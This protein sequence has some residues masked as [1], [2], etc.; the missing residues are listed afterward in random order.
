MPR[1]RVHHEGHLSDQA[2]YSEVGRG[3]LKV[4]YGYESTP[5]DPLVDL[6]DSTSSHK[7]KKPQ[8]EADILS[9]AMYHLAAGML[10]GIL[11]DYFPSLQYYPCESISSASL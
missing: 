6:A 2:C 9:D 8:N 10:P 7:S 1:L 11:A 4:V 3:V 5:E